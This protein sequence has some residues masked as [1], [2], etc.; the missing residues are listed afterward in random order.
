M[1]RTAD[2]ETIFQSRTWGQWPSLDLVRFLAGEDFPEAD[3][4]SALELGPGGGANLWLLARRGFRI[5]GVDIAPS[6][7]SQVRSKLDSDVPGWIEFP[8]GLIDG[9]V[10]ELP[11]GL[12]QFDLILDIQCVSCLSVGDAKQAYE[13]AYRVA[14]PGATLFLQAF[15]DRTYLG[16]A[17]P[18]GDG[19]VRPTD[20]PLAGVPGVR[21]PGGQDE[22]ESLLGPW[23]IR[24]INTATRTV[25]GGSML[26]EEFLVAADKPA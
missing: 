14:K 8:N 18:I 21:I 25:S 2:W 22:L 4:L 11:F 3:S 9:S 20:G 16:D 10:T 1:D 19:R 12:N 24:E 6:A 23:K 26:V 17:P 15:G 13:E 7:I 5:A